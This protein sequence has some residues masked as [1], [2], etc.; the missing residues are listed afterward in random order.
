MIGRDKTSHFSEQCRQILQKMLQFEQE[1]F[2]NWKDQVSKELGSPNSHMKLD[3]TEKVMTLDVNDGM[4]KVNYS[5][6]LTVVMR[7]VRQ[8]IELGFKKQIPPGI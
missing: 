6:R 5:E 8:L 7:D 2:D 3:L 1:T 4:L